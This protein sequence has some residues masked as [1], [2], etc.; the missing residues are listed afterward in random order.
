MLVI[1]LIHMDV[2]VTGYDEFPIQSNEV[3]QKFI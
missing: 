1:V 3:A 2:E